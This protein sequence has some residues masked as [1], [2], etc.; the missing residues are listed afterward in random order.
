MPRGLLPTVPSA[1]EE[2]IRRKYDKALWLRRCTSQ[3][4]GNIRSPRSP[5]SLDLKSA[6]LVLDTSLHISLLHQLFISYVL[7]STS[8]ANLAIRPPAS[9]VSPRRPGVE[10]R[11]LPMLGTTLQA[12]KGTKGGISVW[13]VLLPTTYMHNSAFSAKSRPSGSDRHRT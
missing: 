10:C 1:V 3:L 11:A 5:R 2:I 7:F 6:S 13:L 9:V 12:S 8:L 4:I